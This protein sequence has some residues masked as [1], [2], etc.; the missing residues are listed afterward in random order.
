[1]AGRV[2][3]GG[4]IAG[5]LGGAVM[6][7]LM[8]VVMGAEGSG[9]ATPLN[10]GI[11]AFAKTITPP[12]SMLPTMMGAMGIHLPPET[13][14][15]LK[16]ALAS[17]HIPPAMMS[18][19]G[20]M[21]MGMHMSPDKVHQISDLMAGHAS[22]S[23]MADLLSEMSP[24]GRHEVMD[25]MPVTG[26]NMLLG[27]ITH[28]VLA[29]LLGVL[30]AMMIIGVGIERLSIAALRTPA[31]IIATSVLGGAVVYAVNRWIILPAIDPMMRLVP[32]GWFFV[33]HLLFGL[34]VGIGIAMIASREGLL[35][36]EAS[37][38]QPAAS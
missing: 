21:L 22:N 26:G 25:A 11:P 1:M 4:A 19:M 27:A 7:A 3:V 24:A 14:A 33:A 23:T 30:F 10:L 32:E 38:T 9:Y 16:P 5:L 12:L 15:Q 34:V 29:L 18:Q 36:G 8:V 17:G 2:G 20:E 35:K 6:I 13:M 28:F 37:A 31:G